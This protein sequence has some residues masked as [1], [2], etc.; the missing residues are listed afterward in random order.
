VSSPDFNEVRRS[1]TQRLTS[2]VK[3]QIKAAA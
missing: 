3:R 1:L 2:H